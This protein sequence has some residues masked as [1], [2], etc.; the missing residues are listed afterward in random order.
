[1]TTQQ[2]VIKGKTVSIIGAG[3]PGPPGVPGTG[4]GGEVPDNVALRDGG[5]NWTGTQAL[6][7]NVPVFSYDDVVGGAQFTM[8]NPVRDQADRLIAATLVASIDT[9]TFPDA[10]GVGIGVISISLNAK[11]VRLPNGEG[12]SE[13][14]YIVVTHHIMDGDDPGRV[15]SVEMVVPNLNISYF[16]EDGDYTGVF[17][18]APDGPVL[19]TH[20]TNKQYVDAAIASVSDGSG[21][22]EW[23]TAP[24]GLY[25]LPV[26]SGKIQSKNIVVPSGNPSSP[27][28]FSFPPA[29]NHVGERVE[30]VSAP[31]AATF[32]IVEFDPDPTSA[33][34]N[35]GQI[36]GSIIS[37]ISSD[38]FVLDLT[39]AT[40]GSSFISSIEIDGVTYTS[41]PLDRTFTFTP[42][43]NFAA[44]AEL[45]A[46]LF[47]HIPPEVV[48]LSQ[49]SEGTLRTITTGSESSISF[50]GGT[51]VIPGS[52][53]IGG[54]DIN[55]YETQTTMPGTNGF[56]KALGF[57]DG[58]LD[59]SL[60]YDTDTYTFIGGFGTHNAPDRA[61]F[62]QR[63]TRYVAVEFDPYPGA[64]SKAAMW[65]PERYTQ[66]DSH[67]IIG[68]SWGPKVVANPAYSDNEIIT[69]NDLSRAMLNITDIP[70][71]DYKLTLHIDEGADEYHLLW[72]SDGGSTPSLPDWEYAGISGVQ[73]YVY[74]GEVT[75]G[76]HKISI[77]AT[78]VSV[79]EIGTLPEEFR[80]TGNLWF[81]V[82]TIQVG[83]AGNQPGMI[84][85]QPDGLVYLHGEGQ[86]SWVV[87]PNNINIYAGEIK[88]RLDRP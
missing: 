62:H 86:I 83:G 10:G 16:I 21:P 3:P 30:I 80:P 33:W 49:S 77:A 66:R 56:V 38:P 65:V 55:I 18:T 67:M 72:G 15:M 5:N 87:G 84:V 23:V 28:V 60:Y 81:P 44:A 29:K 79:I 51:S 42:S 53:L 12:G 48:D 59:A 57:T 43:D 68:G 20:V 52:G 8:V 71:G 31:E 26:N 35:V 27:R 39:T 17:P 7:V 54:E 41:D 13:V 82:N 61:P 11:W 19:G 37:R 14:E 25:V 40:L 85:I 47:E 75:L 24:E 63:W 36:I 9:A 50:T 2:V 78:S 45:G 70:S 58:G 76:V 32:G 88:Y 34:L 4:G 22:V 1:M 74:N 73:G 69:L 64:P 46:A 6:A